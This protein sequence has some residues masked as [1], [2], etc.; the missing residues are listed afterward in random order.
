MTY[1]ATA[2][3]ALHRGDTRTALT[4]TAGAQRLYRWPSPAAFPWLAA[5]AAVVLGRTL[6]DVGDQPAARVKATEA[7][8]YLA[9]LLVD[10]ALHDQLDGLLLDLERARARA[11]TDAVD[12]VSL[13]AAELRILPLLQTYLSLGDIARELAVSRNTVKTEV[14]AIYRKLHATNRKQAISRARDI[15]LLQP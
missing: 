14:A 4:A 1:L 3:V 2:R 8:R 7:G 10:G 12:E 13:T 9:L 5:Q 15:G 6:L 11:R